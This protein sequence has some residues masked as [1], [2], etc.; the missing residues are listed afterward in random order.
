MVGQTSDRSYSFHNFLSRQDDNTRN[1]IVSPFMSQKQEV[2]R[3]IQIMLPTIAYIPI[4]KIFIES[5]QHVLLSCAMAAKAL[6]RHH[7]FSFL[8][9]YIMQASVVT[10]NSCCCLRRKCAEFREINFKQR[11]RSLRQANQTRQAGIAL[12]VIQPN[13]IVIHIKREQYNEMAISTK[14]VKHFNNRSPGT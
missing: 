6:H 1:K 9:I 5:Y 2:I 14:I 7:T 10:T 4:L 12:Q 11:I 8:Y 13:F 3:K